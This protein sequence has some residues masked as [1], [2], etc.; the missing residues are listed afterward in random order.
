[1]SWKRNIL[2]FVLCPVKSPAPKLGPLATEI[3]A[4]KRTQWV[5]EKLA[6][7]PQVGLLNG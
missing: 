4:A 5:H 1:M 2:R 7:M 6:Q 3:I